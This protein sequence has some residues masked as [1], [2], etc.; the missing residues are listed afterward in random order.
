MIDLYIS[1]IERLKEIKSKEESVK[2]AEDAE[3]K[4]YVDRW[5]TLS[6]K[7]IRKGKFDNISGDNNLINSFPSHMYGNIIL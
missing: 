1:L 4:G 7:D 6:G 5:F 2:N 3:E